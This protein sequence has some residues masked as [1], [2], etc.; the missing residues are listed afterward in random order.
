MNIDTSKIRRLRDALVK[1]GRLAEDM[2][3]SGLRQDERH[4]AA[5]QR[6][7]PMIEVMYLMMSID[8][9]LGDEER[10]AIHGAIKLLTD[11]GIAKS[12]LDEMLKEFGALAQQEGVEARLQAIGH[13]ISRDQLDRETAFSL[14]AAV[15]MADDEVAEEESLLV[16]SVAEW[17]GIS[18]QRCDELLRA[19]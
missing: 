6:V 12:E 5:V 17:F 18:S 14:A 1:G 7:S 4:L 9:S 11:S 15:A 8:G 2:G 13:R 3:D 19:F 10:V 16:K